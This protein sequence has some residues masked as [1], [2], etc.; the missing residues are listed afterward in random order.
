MAKLDREIIKAKGWALGRIFTASSAPILVDLIT[1]NHKS[2][3]SV[4]IAVTHDC[5]IIN[6]CLLNEPYVEYLSAQP[7]A[8]ENGQFINARNIR[9]LHLQIEVHGTPTWFEV[10]MARRGF[11]DRGSIETCE[12]DVNYVLTD[13]NHLVLKRWLSSRYISQTFP[14]RFNELTGPLVANSKAPLIK[15]LSSEVGKA[16]TSI[17]ISLTPDNLD[18]PVDQNYEVIIILVFKEKIAIELGQDALE[19]LAEQVEALLGA[20][21]GLNPVTVFALPDSSIN[22]DQIIKMTRW[23]L[24]YVSLKDDAE[25]LAVENLE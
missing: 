1:E 5:S 19:Q 20:I 7:I 21:Q 4:Y 23:N 6:P 8:T 18:L 3:Q 12:P 13:D 11:I 22:Y 2:D 24:D 25:V 15:V 16:C 14:D 10:S 17:F 9:R